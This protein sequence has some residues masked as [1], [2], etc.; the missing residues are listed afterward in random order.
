LLTYSVLG[1]IIGQSSNDQVEISL[2]KSEVLN[3]IGV[4]EK[5]RGFP[6]VIKGVTGHALIPNVVRCEW[7]GILTIKKDVIANIWFYIHWN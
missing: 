5:S 6:N 4:Y 1:H 7:I 3:S 2:W